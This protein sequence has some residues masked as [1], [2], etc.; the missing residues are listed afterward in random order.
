MSV[1]TPPADPIL[2]M[3]AA[4]VPLEEIVSDEI[5]GIIERMLIIA[6]GERTDPSKRSMVGLAAPQIGIPKQ[7]IIVDTGVD[8][9]R[10]A[11]GELEVFINPKITWYS[12]ELIEG[13]EGCFSVD[14]R[15]LGIVHRAATIKCTAYDRQGNFISKEFTEFTA[16]IFQ[17][18][19]DHL[20]GIRFPDRVGEE[21]VLQW[22]EED[23]YPE[24]RK[25]WKEWPVRITYDTWRA[26]KSGLPY[27][28]PN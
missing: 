28:K 11:F 14:E 22:V 3:K 20:N 17:H 6:G 26:M 1:F 2:M 21:G 24:Y 13:R 4:E 7:I 23:Q 15:V 12:E 8:A 27:P 25:N 18:E 10:S 5:Q 19:T 9:N 16:R